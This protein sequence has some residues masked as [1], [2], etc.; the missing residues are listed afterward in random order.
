MWQDLVISVIVT[1]FKVKVR[2]KVTGTQ[3]NLAKKN[4]L[5]SIDHGIWLSITVVKVCVSVTCMSDS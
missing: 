5:I 4:F 1:L 3:E 2:V